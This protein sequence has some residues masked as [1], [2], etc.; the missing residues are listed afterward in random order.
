MPYR[1]LKALV[2]RLAGN[3]LQSSPE[4]KNDSAYVTRPCL[5]TRLLLVAFVLLAIVMSL[6]SEGRSDET[7]EPRLGD[8]IFRPF[9]P[10]KPSASHLRDFPSPLLSPPFVQPVKCVLSVI[11]IFIHSLQHSLCFRF[12]CSFNVLS[13]TSVR[14]CSP[15]FLSFSRNYHFI[16]KPALHCNSNLPSDVIRIQIMSCS[17][18]NTS[19]RRICLCLYHF[20]RIAIVR[21]WAR[22]A[23][24][25]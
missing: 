8:G 7:R 4:S 2:E 6:L 1:F 20:I 24:S 17:C 5:F 9:L 23:Q 18:N 13:F 22:M 15:P 14:I 3:W 10:P 21:L 12:M 16:Y 19:L 11:V 25:V